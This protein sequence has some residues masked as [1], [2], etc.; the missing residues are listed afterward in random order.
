MDPECHMPEPYCGPLKR[1]K[2][3]LFSTDG[4]WVLSAAA[5][6]ETLASLC[7]YRYF[8]GYKTLDNESF[9]V[10]FTDFASKPFV[11]LIYFILLCTVKI[12]I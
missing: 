2:S 8:K 1:S 7:G 10:H 5:A 9:M 12:I 11:K 3:P 6:M 4:L